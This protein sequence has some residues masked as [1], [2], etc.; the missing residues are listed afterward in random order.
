M[1]EMK[2]SIELGEKTVALLSRFIDT[3]S[4]ENKTDVKCPDCDA[5]PAAN[6]VVEE[7]E[8][9]PQSAAYEIPPLEAE[10]E[11]E[12]PKRRR[13]SASESSVR[14]H[15]TEPEDKTD[16]QLLPDPPVKEPE[17]DKLLEPKNRQ[18]DDITHDDIRELIATVLEEDENNRQKI[19]KQ[20]TK[21]GAKSIGAIKEDDLTDF[22]EFLHSLK[23]N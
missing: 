10:P 18:D 14:S 12:K 5:V 15:Y 1:F 7:P 13:K 6:S 19:L 11:P 8:K 17:D 4:D 21:V 20:L 9:R 3:I 16:T 22:Y 23:K 2:I